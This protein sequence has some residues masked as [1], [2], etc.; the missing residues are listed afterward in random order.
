MKRRTAKRTAP[1]KI[2]I[3]VV[4]YV[5]IGMLTP[6]EM[7]PVRAQTFGG[8]DP[9]HRERTKQ[10]I[11]ELRSMDLDA[12]AKN[13]LNG[14][15]Y[16]YPGHMTSMTPRLD[17]FDTV[18]TNRGVDAFLAKLEALPAP[19]RQKRCK[20]YFDML[21]KEYEETI[22]R[23]IRRYEDP[24]APKNDKSLKTNMEA[25]VASI[26]CTSRLCTFKDVYDEFKKI[27]DFARKTSERID[28]TPAD[29]FSKR[30]LKRYLEP[31]SRCQLA[32]LADTFLKD[33]KTPEN[34]KK[35]VEALL[36]DC[37]VVNGEVTAWDCEVGAFDFI[38]VHEGVPVDRS[39][40]VRKVTLFNWGPPGGV[41]RQGDAKYQEKIINE[42]YS[43][44][45]PQ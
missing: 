33:P 19:E 16:D 35:K 22:F 43:V 11:A 6:W 7:A 38:H 28:K 34:R 1:M 14:K 17:V 12:L 32:L 29:D 36:A 10:Y 26:Y 41:N 27:K 21:F 45:V 44:V 20:A 24:K 25:M 5:V 40:G 37:F 9:V 2:F 13:L 4:V 31:D 30:L 18:L 23:V 42:L 8:G 39:R 15:H 3:C